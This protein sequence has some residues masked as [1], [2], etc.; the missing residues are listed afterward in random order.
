MIKALIAERDGISLY[1]YIDE[2]TN[3]VKY[4]MVHN[5]LARDYTF[6]K[7]YSYTKANNY[8]NKLVKN[9]DDRCKALEQEVL[10]MVLKGQN[11]DS[12]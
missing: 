11:N 6:M 8:Y 9:F 7:F 12:K 4:Y 1:A 10:A 3:L 5:Y 2:P